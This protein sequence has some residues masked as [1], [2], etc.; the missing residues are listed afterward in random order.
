[1][2]IW[3][4]LKRNSLL[5]LLTETYRE[6]NTD[7][8]SQL[9][10]SV[11]YSLLFS[12]FPFALAIISISGFIIESSSFQQQIINGLAALVPTARNLIA[13]TLRE[14]ASAREITG[15]LAIIGLIYSAL[16]FFNSLRVSLDTAW[17]IKQP[18]PFLK[19][20]LTN[21]LMMLFA[22]IAFIGFIWIST[23]IRFINEIAVQNDIVKVTHSLIFSRV[24]FGVI[25]IMPAFGIIL[26]LYKFIPNKRPKWRDIWP[27]ALSAAVSLEVIRLGFIWY[28]KNFATY[29]L[30]YGPVGGDRLPGFHLYFR[31]GASVFRQNQR[32]KAASE[33]KTRLSLPAESCGIVC[34]APC[35]MQQ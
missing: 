4:T 25:S 23:W 14:A 3:Q 9:A 24:I 33:L 13:S 34:T 29:N 18:Y 15:L 35:N 12:L 32:R 10:A 31:L 21:I 20:Q 30:V 26:L 16:A 6:F 27:G 1:M 22:F 28:V 2:N 11:S 17:G 19:G 7:N 8:A 5:I